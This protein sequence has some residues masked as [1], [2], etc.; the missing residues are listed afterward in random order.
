MTMSL[1][2]LNLT[3]LPY[4]NISQEKR[5]NN[6]GAAFS[7][8]FRQE[9]T[10]EENKELMMKEDIQNYNLQTWGNIFKGMQNM[11][12]SKTMN[13]YKAYMAKVSYGNLKTL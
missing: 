8:F 1:D 9:Q 4:N 2:T 10:K 3:I 6:N 7:N 12:S 5:S 13:N 11:S